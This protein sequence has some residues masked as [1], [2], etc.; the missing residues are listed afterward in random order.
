MRLCDSLALNL[1]HFQ[2]A[3]G[4]EGSSDHVRGLAG[5]LLHRLPH[6]GQTGVCGCVWVCF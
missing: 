4:A 6:T 2:Q 5:H 3:G 1:C